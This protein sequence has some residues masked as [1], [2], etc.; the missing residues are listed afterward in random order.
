[1]TP[2][3][4]DPRHTA[5]PAGWPADIAAHRPAPTPR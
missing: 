3:N 1:L 4:R 2:P 5:P